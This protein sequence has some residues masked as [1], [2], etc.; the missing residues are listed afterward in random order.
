VLGLD[1]KLVKVAVGLALE[2]E[3]ESGDE[4]SSVLDRLLRL[5]A[6]PDPVGVQVLHDELLK[7]DIF[8]DREVG[9]WLELALTG[10]RSDFDWREVV[11]DMQETELDLFDLAYLIE[12]SEYVNEFRAFG[13]L[14]WMNS[15]GV[16]VSNI[17][18]GNWVL[19]KIDVNRAVH[20]SLAVSV[21]KIRGNE[22]FRSAVDEHR[23][24]TADYY[25]RVLEFPCESNIPEDR[26]D[27]I[28][29]VQELLI[30]LK[31][32]YRRE[33]ANKVLSDVALYSIEKLGVAEDCLLDSKTGL[34]QAGYEVGLVYEYLK[35]KVEAIRNEEIRAWIVKLLE[36]IEFLSSHVPA[37]PKPLVEGFE[38]VNA[39]SPF[40]KKRRGKSSL[41]R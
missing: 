2:A 22:D 11:M 39:E 19:A 29:E 21:E 17:R 24:A 36:R 38:H 20:R 5:Y 1:Q 15:I 3:M 8:E 25:E 41:I 40:E 4:D 7:S 23:K 12:T 6:N 27:T 10:R 18:S 28:L 31:R 33:P 14:D 37:L 35:E 30:E 16:C 34:E 26:L 13:L 9:L 32:K